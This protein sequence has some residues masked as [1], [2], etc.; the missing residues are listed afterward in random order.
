MSFL[1]VERQQTLERFVAA[2]AEAGRLHDWTGL[3][4]FYCDDALYW[5]DTGAVQTVARG[6]DEICNLVLVRDQLG[7]MNWTYPFECWAVGGEHAFTRWW[8]RGPGE[9]PDGSFYQVIGMS[10]IR[11]EEGG[12]RFV[13]QVDLFDLG[14]LVQLCDEIPDELL[15]PIMKEKQLP[16]MRRLVADAIVGP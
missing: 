3:A 7:W 9:R 16:V 2:N 1:L 15:L 8:S 5:Y 4:G 6:P 13:E 11:F 10:H 12:P 14:K